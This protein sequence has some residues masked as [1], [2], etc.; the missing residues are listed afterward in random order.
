MKDVFYEIIKR[1]VS[2]RSV[3]GDWMDGLVSGLG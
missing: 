2:G 3:D 1:V